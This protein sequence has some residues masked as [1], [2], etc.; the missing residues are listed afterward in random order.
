MKWN[1]PDYNL[2][3]RRGEQR[4][5]KKFLLWPRF[6]RNEIRWMETAWILEEVASEYDHCQTYDAWVEQYFV[7]EEFAK[8]CGLPIG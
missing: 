2:H 3:E 7:T 6:L 4:I 1:N 8:T 5:R